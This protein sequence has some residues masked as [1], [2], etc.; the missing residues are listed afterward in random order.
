[1]IRGDGFTLI[2]LLVVIAIIAVLAGLLLP[3]LARAK[4]KSKQIQ[5]VS[6]LRQ[7]GIAMHAF[8]TEHRDKFPCHVPLRDGGV[9]TRPNAWEHFLTLSNELASTRVLICPSDRERTAAADFSST[10]GGFASTTNR[11]KSL[12]YFAG[13]HVY[14][15]KGQTL[16]AGDRDITNGT[17]QTEGCGPAQLSSGAMPFPPD[18]LSRVKWSGKLHRNSGNLCMADGRVTQSAP[19]ALRKLLVRS[20]PGGDPNNKNHVLL[21]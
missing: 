13:T 19:L 14:Y 5:C 15:D 4:E 7:V 3:A 20:M 12:S 10:P 2:E 21:P 18:Q 8:A 1:M 6:Q 17:G 11:N 9:L 16:L